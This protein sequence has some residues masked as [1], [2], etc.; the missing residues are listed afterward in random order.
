MI[1][2]GERGLAF[3]LFAANILLA[4]IANILED[5]NTIQ[6]VDDEGQ[7]RTQRGGHFQGSECKAAK[8]AEMGRRWADGRTCSTSEVLNVGRLLRVKILIM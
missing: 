3:Q 5:R 7:K 8:R 4:E 1:R 6:S 2:R